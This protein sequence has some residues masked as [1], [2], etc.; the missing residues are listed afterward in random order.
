[1][2]WLHTQRHASW[3]EIV[4]TRRFTIDWAVQSFRARPIWWWRPVISIKEFSQLII[5]KWVAHHHNISLITEKKGKVRNVLKW[6]QSLIIREPMSA[7]SI[8]LSVME[9]SIS[10]R[11]RERE[12][13]NQSFDRFS[14]L[15]HVT[16]QDI[17]S[18]YSTT[19]A[20]GATRLCYGGW[21]G[22]CAFYV[23]VVYAMLL[24]LSAGS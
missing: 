23:C 20:S 5:W 9:T 22:E 11:E 16:R 17:S 10:F 8:L 19:D 6:P 13:I 21:S 4:Y 24:V 3:T 1:M 18:Y 15:W 7:P 14:R 2:K 12:E